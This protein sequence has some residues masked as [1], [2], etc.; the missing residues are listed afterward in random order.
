MQN[1]LDIVDSI[2]EEYCARCKRNNLFDLSKIGTSAS[3]KFSLKI[4][5]GKIV[6]ESSGIKGGIFGL[7][8]AAE[9]I[10]DNTLPDAIEPLNNWLPTRAL[11]LPENYKVTDESCSRALQLGYNTLVVN[12]IYKTKVPIEFILKAKVCEGG[13]SPANPEYSESIK[14][15][16]HDLPRYCSGIF[17]ESHFNQPSFSQNPYADRFT[18]REL[19]IKEMKTLETHLPKGMRLFYQ[20]PNNCE[21]LATW[22]RHLAHQAGEYTTLAF[23]PND[24]LIP[25]L[26]SIPEKIVTPLLSVITTTNKPVEPKETPILH[27]PRHQIEGAFVQADFIPKIDTIPGAQLWVLSKELMG[28]PNPQDAW[29]RWGNI[30]RPEWNFHSFQDAFRLAKE[31]N[32]VSD[33]NFQNSDEGSLLRQEYSL[34]LKRL[35]RIVS[36]IPKGLR[37]IFE[38]FLQE[39]KFD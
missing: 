20:L 23:H 21:R 19:L 14:K 12:E 32:E 18:Y 15:I 28:K 9:A 10:L 26:S 36:S 2:N 6:I 34:K 25:F 27:V 8:H 29:Y 3:E 7:I 39:I 38:Y 13:L 30:Y 5:S 24:S 22:L 33:K 4:R 1:T 37:E 16:I 11:F 17:W 31:I 35:E